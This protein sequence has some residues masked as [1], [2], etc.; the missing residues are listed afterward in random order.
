MSCQ[1][2]RR[3]PRPALCDLVL[4][5]AR[6]A[7]ILAV[8]GAVDTAVASGATVVNNSYGA[9][10]GAYVHPIAGPSMPSLLGSRG[11]SSLGAVISHDPRVL[12]S[13]LPVPEDDGG[14]RHLVGA[15]IPATELLATNGRVIDL[16]ALQAECTVL[17]VYPHRTSW[18]GATDTGLGSDPGCARLH[19]R[20]VFVPR[21][22]PRAAEAEG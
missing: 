3:N 17:Y 16:A 4:V 14:A 21:P 5:E 12:P 10:E 7:T 1:P 22:L 8:A 6:R 9:Q 19:T 13:G 15:R 20:I 18:R 11:S 2:S